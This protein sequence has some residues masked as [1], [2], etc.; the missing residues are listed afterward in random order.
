V[1]DDIKNTK[2]IKSATLNDVNVISIKEPVLYCESLKLA[3]FSET[4]N[5]VL[6]QMETPTQQN[7][8]SLI[9]EYVRLTI[10]VRVLTDPQHL[11]DYLIEQELARRCCSLLCFKPSDLEKALNA[12][13]KC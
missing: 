3:L 8:S 10:L 7:K 1:S 11:D 9:S 13:V 4:S 5:R 6:L 2:H 12:I